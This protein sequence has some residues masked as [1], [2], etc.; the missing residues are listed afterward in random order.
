MNVTK[1]ILCV[2]IL[3]LSG[4]SLAVQ[5]QLEVKV[6]GLHDKNTRVIEND[7]ALF[8]GDSFQ[9]EVLVNKSQFVYSFFL[10]S[11]EKLTSLDSGF[12]QSGSLYALPANGHWYK[13]D[14]NVGKEVLIVVGS[15]LPLEVDKLSLDIK[16]KKDISTS[17]ESGFVKVFRINHMDPKVIT[18]S[19]QV[20]DKKGKIANNTKINF[21]NNLDEGKVLKGPALV[22]GVIGKL[23][24]YS[25]GIGVKTRG[26]K[27]VHVFKNASPSVVKVF[28]KTGSGSGS[29]ISEDGLILTN[30]HVVKGAK[31]AGIAF[32]PKRR[33]KVSKDDLIMGKVIKI[34]GETDLALI[35]LDSIPKNIKPLVIS[36]DDPEIGQDV[37]AIGHPQGGSDWTYTK[38]YIS[39]LNYDDKWSYKDTTHS[40]LLMIQSQTPINP[41]NSGGPLLN[42]NGDIV[43]VN[44]ATSPDY[45]SANFAISSE[46]I[47]KFL[48]QKGDI[49]TNKIKEK[50]TA[51][52]ENL[53]KISEKLGVNV[54]L[55]EIIDVEEN[56]SEDFKVSVD[57]DKNGLVEM[58]II[59]LKDK[60]KGRV[61]I[62]D[63][64][65]DGKWDMMA[66][67]KDNNGK[68]DTYVF[69]KEDSDETDVIGYDDDED[70]K[71]DR[72]EQV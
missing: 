27:E 35:Q 31:E 34:N 69:S 23:I 71:V 48:K 52:D 9:L 41:G 47:R 30:W 55:V 49:K 54:V 67:D 72:Y 25:D 7:S 39:Q 28:T 4:L 10:D 5:E 26:I 33:G 57:D 43:G 16:N 6:R 60:S 63:T 56:G 11:S 13:L 70:G 20:S 22:S 46:D 14:D 12:K 15:T 2:F 37:H 51:K 42:N 61:V 1:K 38:G 66:L 50:K 21:L 29:L 59:L 65:E 17:L 3:C 53:K 58:T 45:V 8:S 19:S 68:S 40:A 18:R 62:Y 64:N 44:S 36:T 24:S 32:I